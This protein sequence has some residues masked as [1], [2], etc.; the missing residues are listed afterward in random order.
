MLAAFLVAVPAL[1]TPSP[2]IS[3]KR[4]EAQQVLVQIDELDASLGRANERLNHANVKLDRVRGQMEENRRALVVAQRNLRRSQQTIV[5]R[6][7]SL[8]TKGEPSTLEVILG[9]RSLV[10]VLNVIDTENRV[11]SL[12]ADVVNQVTKFKR[13]VNRH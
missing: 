4:A 5:R 13:T 11:A 7:V 3:A 9:A 6:L 2:S 8:Y 1:A 10:E 12:D